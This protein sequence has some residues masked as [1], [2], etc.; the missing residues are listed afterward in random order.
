MNQPTWH[1]LLFNATLLLGM[2]VL[3]DLILLQ[4]RGASRLRQVISGIVLGG[5]GIAIILTAFPL[6]DGVIFDTR[7]VLLSIS[8]LFFGFLPTLIAVGL[9]AA[10]RLYLGGG[11]ALTG[12]MVILTSALI[13]WV[14]RYLRRR[15]L[16]KMGWWELYLFGWVVH[17]ICSCGC[18]PCRVVWRA[19]CLP[20]LPCRC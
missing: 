11:G 6:I 9:T 10:Y 5:I 7:S 17:L 18:T 15:A 19:R 2:S 20:R 1:G 14:W 3:Y 8:G 13:G 12:V 4:G 16:D